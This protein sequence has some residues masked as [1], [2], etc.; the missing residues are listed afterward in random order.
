MLEINRDP[1]KRDLKIFSLLLIVFSGVAAWWVNWK[2]EA[3]AA[4]TAIA[5]VGPVLGIVCFL[6]PEFA[7]RVYVGWMLAVSP[8][9]WIVSHVILA[10]AYFLVFAP[11]GFVMRLF[12][13][14]P[15]RRTF[16]AGAASYWVRRGE[17]PKPEDYFRQF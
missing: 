3:P 11:V 4:A 12:G 16:D 10:A 1:P 5:I 13:Y 6:W 9:N 17:P 8:I 2:H 7:R 15:L 14:D